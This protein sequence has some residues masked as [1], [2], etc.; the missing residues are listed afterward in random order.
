MID[1][2][3]DRVLRLSGKHVN[4]FKT[5]VDAK[6]YSKHVYFDH[7]TILFNIESLVSKT[8]RQQLPNTSLVLLISR[9]LDLYTFDV[10][11]NHKIYF[12]KACIGFLD[13][14]LLLFKGFL[15]FFFLLHLHESL[16]S[17]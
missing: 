16:R 12:T 4:L 3:F 14:E 1:G 5:I 10:E 9:Q 8:K 15:F 17:L 13:H 11:V 6:S 2:R 7:R